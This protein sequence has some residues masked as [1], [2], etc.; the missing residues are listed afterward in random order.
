MT[1]N[2]KI[3]RKERKSKKADHAI[4]EEIAGFA[5]ELNLNVEELLGWKVYDQRLVV[6]AANGMK[7]SKGLP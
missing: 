2:E 1:E 7:F 6:I 5:K 4:P 3:V